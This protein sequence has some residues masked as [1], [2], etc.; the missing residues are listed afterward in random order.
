MGVAAGAD[1]ADG[2]DAEPGRPHTDRGE[3]VADRRLVAP[4]IAAWSSAACCLAL[5]GRGGL[6]VGGLLLAGVIVCLRTRR[7]VVALVLL[8]AA[9]A[10]LT[11]GLRVT[12]S[13]AGTVPA[14]AAAEAV[15]TADV[16]LSGDPRVVSG[17]FGDQVV[18]EADAASVTGRGSTVQGRA[19]VLVLADVDSGVG[20][21]ALGTTVR[22]VARLAP[23]DSADLAALVLVSR[24]EAVRADPAWWW[25]VAGG[26][27]GGVDRATASRGQAGELVPG[28]VVGDD[29][30]LTPETVE[31]FRTSGLT[32]LLAVSGTNLTL[33]LGALLLVARLVGGRGR[34]LLVVGVLGAAGFV[35][36]AR[37]EPSVVRAAA[38]GLVALAGLTSG[39]RRRGLRALCVAVL[40]L[41]LVDPWLSRSVGFALS[42]L[43]TAA[44]LVLA[45]TW[46]DALAR[47]LPRWAAEAVAVPMAAQLAC[48]PLV[49]AISGQ[50]SLVAV[51][52]NVLVAPAVGPATVLGLVAGLAEVAWAP[53]GRL[54][55]WLAVLPAGWIVTVG[56]V[57]AD[58][59]GADVEWG[60]SVTACC[61]SRRSAPP[62]PSAPAGCCG[63]GGRAWRSRCCSS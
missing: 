57:A 34:G 61:C 59:P 18:V 3:P 40:V 47:W 51:A 29:S 8:A 49:A 22:V 63:T 43:A 7:H 27:R 5:P 44:I 13:Q 24:V 41:V 38:M 60:T 21:L 36:L 58:L 39:D 15:V 55:G 2:D 54:V 16:V 11:A 31:D 42:A 37:P 25:T 26:V 9:A 19:P 46:R 10:A 33:V 6:A 28:L 53:A 32:H 35:L 52:A 62:S 30:D 50:A 48:T 23:S 17:A 12:H 14:L 4:A 1:A 20:D 56:G 45:P